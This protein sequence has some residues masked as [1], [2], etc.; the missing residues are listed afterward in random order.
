MKRIF[1]LLISLSSAAA[2]AGDTFT[3]NV[4]DNS[5]SV[6][7]NKYQVIYSSSAGMFCGKLHNG[8][9]VSKK[10]FEPDAPARI[11]STGKIVVDKEV[12]NGF[13]TYKLSDVILKGPNDVNHPIEFVSIPVLNEYSHVSLGRQTVAEQFNYTCKDNT[14][15]CKGQGDIASIDSEEIFIY[16]EDK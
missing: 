2:F 9:F 10:D 11:P 16:V 14:W 8:S 15:K 7:L 3:I 6:R 13:C 12:K 5:N 4:Q 1:A